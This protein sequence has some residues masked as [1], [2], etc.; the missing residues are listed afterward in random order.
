M[1]IKFSNEHTARAA[2]K[3]FER[4]GYRARCSGRVLATDC[5]TLLAVPVVHRSV[6]FDRIQEL[7][8]ASGAL[9]GVLDAPNEVTIG[10]VD[11]ATEQRRSTPTAN[12]S[13]PT[14]VTA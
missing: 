1:R 10:G 3:V 5:P 13:I 7:D 12:V 6:G 8:I 9:R 14:E 2:A 4:Y 11:S